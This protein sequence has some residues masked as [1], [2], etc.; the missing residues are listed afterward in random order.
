[1]GETY[2]GLTIRIGGDTTSLQKALKGVNHDAANLGNVLRKAGQA[3]RIDPYSINAARIKMDVLS[4]SV[5]NSYAKYNLLKGAYNQKLNSE[6]LKRASQYVKETGD[7]AGLAEERY[8]KLDKALEKVKRSLASM[9]GVKLS[10]DGAYTAWNNNFEENLEKL[11]TSGKA[12][13][14]DLLSEYDKLA[15][16]HS[17]AQ[18]QLQMTKV[19]AQFT[20]LEAEMEKTR[21]KAVQLAGSYVDLRAD[22]L[23]IG[24]QPG[25]E[26]ARKA[27]DQA[28]RAATEL[29]SRLAK[30][31][32]ALQLDPTS[33]D[34][35][36]AKE[37]LLGDAAKT[38]QEKVKALETELEQLNNN[39]LDGVVA[40]TEYS[41]RATEEL[42]DEWVEARASMEQ[43]ES[44]LHDLYDQQQRLANHEDVGKTYEQLSSEIEE[45]KGKLATFTAQE[46]EAEEAFKGAKAADEVNR[47][48]IELGEAKAQAKRYEEAARSASTAT[49][50][51]GS[52]GADSVHGLAYNLQNLGWTFSATV[53]PHI[54]MAME[55]AVESADEIDGAYRDM[56]KTVDGSEEGFENLK[57]SAEDFARTHVTS[58]DQMLEI[59]ALGGQLGIAQSNLGDFAEV[60][61][62]ISV[63]TNLDAETA[64]TDLG[65]LAAITQMT[66]E[67][68]SSFA[69]ALVRL[70]NNSATQESD[71]MDIVTRIGSVGTICGFTLPQLTGLSA[72]LASTGQNSE[73]AGTALS[74][75]FS[76]LES[77][78]AN[79]G[80]DLEALASVSKMSAQEFADAWKSSPIDALTAFINGL[81][82]IDEQGGSVDATLE[83]MG[84]T[85]VRQKQA[86]EGLVQESK[87]S[88]DEQG[89]AVN[90]LNDALAMSQ[91]AWDG[92]SDK[93][94]QAGDAANEAD[95]KAEGFSGQLAILQNNAQILGSE[96]SEGLLPIL[97]TGSGILEGVTSSLEGMTEGQKQALLAAI[98]LAGVA[99]PAMTTIGAIKSA[100]TSFNASLV[101]QGAMMHQS[102]EYL[103]NYVAALKSSGAPTYKVAAAQAELSNAYKAQEKMAKKATTA[104]NA[105]S[106]AQKAAVG[107]AIAAAAIVV[108]LLVKQY[109]ELKEK[110]DRARE[111][112]ILV[113]S[114]YKAT[115]DM[116]EGVAPATEDVA[117]ANEHVAMSYEDIRK[118]VDEAREALDNF[119][120][121]V[122]DS[123]TKTAATNAQLESYR[124]TIDRLGGKAEVGTTQMA[125]LELA[126][127][128]VNEICGTN[129]YVDEE[130]GS[131]REQGSAAEVTA[132]QIDSLIT[133]KE[134]LLRVEA[135]QDQ[136]KEAYSAQAV[137]GHNLDEANQ[138]LKSAQD[139]YDAKKAYVDQLRSAGVAENDE[140]LADAV[141][142]MLAAEVEVK[143]L[144]QSVDELTGNYQE[145]T[146]DVQWWSDQ[147]VHASM[148]AR[149]YN[150]AIKQA[151]EGNEAMKQTMEGL[152]VNIDDFS[153]SLTLAGVSTEDWGNVTPEVLNDIVA[154]Y[155]N[156]TADIMHGLSDFTKDSEEEW[157][158]NLN[159]A[160]SWAEGL[161]DV[162]VQAVQTVATIT[163]KSSAEIGQFAK[164]AGVQGDDAMQAFAA[165][166]QSGA[167]LAVSAASAASGL[168]LDEFRSHA[169]EYGIS[170]DEQMEAYANALNAHQSEVQAAAIAISGKSV[171]EFNNAVQQYGIAGDDATMRF[172]QALRDNGGDVAAAAASVAD[173]AQEPIDQAADEVGGSDGGVGDMAQ[174]MAG[175]EDAVA[176]TA[177]Q[178][179]RDLQNI[180]K[181]GDSYT[182]G[183]HLMQNLINGLNSKKGALTGVV[184]GIA[185]TISAFLHQTTADVGP[186]RYTDQW[187]GHLV[188]NII[189]GMSDRERALAR[190]AAS[191][192]EAISSNFSPNV[193]AVA[194]ADFASSYANEM[195]SRASNATTNKS[196]TI[197]FDGVTL[198]GRSDIEGVTQDYLTELVRLMKQ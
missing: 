128:G 97:Q 68:Y 147:L 47:V 176:G 123:S 64:A 159:A 46:K 5:Q 14:Q 117:E 157:A 165:A 34:L 184:S 55:A 81:R 138:Q 91:D 42:H 143:N 21:A 35:V 3:L 191:A 49:E 45:A 74:N 141:N 175:S 16:R 104:T 23:R 179:A 183:N 40:D 122:K 196:Y 153:Q 90:V 52:K 50:E 145:N 195:A 66:T 100:T 70:G 43:A 83:G 181:S 71:I 61:S 102:V 48:T 115:K 76:F 84:I 99:G 156:S 20:D 63:A 95:K 114:A 106:T 198:N 168:T 22:M 132:G 137:T 112:Q 152:G 161:S 79:G 53:T 78:A 162:G 80:D 180:D 127:Q 26:Q 193:Q 33:T 60:V 62:S 120:R 135:L 15:A 182:W 111:S 54:W 1:M 37:L 72:A 58:T 39:G 174:G 130:T 27:L 4:Q 75:T 185:N 116:M 119:Y 172:A 124:D 8:N 57:Q 194:S 169:E 139:N 173:S 150:N 13:I 12:K 146:E 110:E 59:Q 103:E 163:G 171:D 7:S 29:D 144:S 18:D 105:L 82:E 41:A 167:S 140:T 93:W 88:F 92:V 189:N 113:N 24:N 96:L 178:V 164:D 154:Q 87:T 51:L 17:T 85:A 129:Y 36:R 166:I 69:D 186:L 44:A 134:K 6:Q 187:G 188:D 126:V 2:R 190:Q 192:A 19:I 30:V 149:L 94:G 118:P 9:D 133:S 151:I 65:H 77:A 101:N 158:K 142:D 89:N 136:L 109:A 125:E 28:D 177:D 25:M 10:E 31:N 108:A 170:G 121:S 148:D 98:A 107:G 73:A 155:G 38:A 67:Q 131:I 86:I 197:V 160:L 32:A 56:R 11:R